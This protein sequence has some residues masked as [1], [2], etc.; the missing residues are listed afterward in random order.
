[1]R[2]RGTVIHS[3]VVVEYPSEHLFL[4]DPTQKVVEDGRRQL[5]VPS[6]AQ[7]KSPEMEHLPLGNA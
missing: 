3:G 1:L 4:L 2:K 5:Q 6:V 7:R